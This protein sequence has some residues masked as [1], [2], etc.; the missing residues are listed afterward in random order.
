MKAL[1]GFSKIYLHRDYV[2]FRKG[3]NGLS[4]LVEG[5]MG[6]RPMSA[7][8]LFVFINRK[9]DR[10]RMLYWDK[11]GFAFW[12]KHLEEAKFRWPKKKA[13]VICLSEQELSWL[14]DGVDIEKIK[15]HEALIYERVG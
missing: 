3:L 6:L 15:S 5:S 2:D 14:L 11:T 13:S 7:G 4:L 8:S 1:S 10:L 12:H 9:R